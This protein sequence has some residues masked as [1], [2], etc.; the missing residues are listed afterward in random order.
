[1]DYD[2]EEAMKRTTIKALAKRRCD[3]IRI[4]SP[5]LWF[6]LDDLACSACMRWARD[7]IRNAEVKR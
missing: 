2:G 7:K 1:M 4:R 6:F 5:H 3:R